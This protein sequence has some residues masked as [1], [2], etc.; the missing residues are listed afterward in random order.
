MSCLQRMWAYLQIIWVKAP[1][2]VE[3]MWAEARNVCGSE[4]LRLGAAT[5]SPAAWAVLASE[6]SSSKPMAIIRSQQVH[7][8]IA[9]MAWQ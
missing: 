8:P 4:G 6:M 7:D 2:Y 3:P 5:G 9:L 1:F